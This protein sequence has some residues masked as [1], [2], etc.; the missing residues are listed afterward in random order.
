MRIV[1]DPGTPAR[2]AARRLVAFLASPRAARLVGQP[3]FWLV[4]RR[5]TIGEIDLARVRRVLVI[6]LDEI[7]DVAMTAPFLRE[8]RRN[9]AGAWISL[10]VKPGVFNLV[11]RC[12][13][14][15]EVLTFDWNTPPRLGR[16]RRHGRALRLAWRHLWARRF[17]LAVVPRWDVDHYHA[18]FVAYFSGA[19]WR[20]AYSEQVAALKR[21][22]N[23]G[24]DA[25]FTHVL[26]DD[27]PRHEVE[28]NLQVLRALGGTVADDRLELWVAPEDEAYADDVLRRNSVAPGEVLVGL[29]PAGGNSPFKQWPVDR[30]IA[31]AR[32]LLAASPVRL[33][34][35][36]GPGEEA[37]GEEMARTLGPSAINLVGRTTLRQ[38]AA[39]LHRCRLYVG[40][41]AGPMH[42]AAAVGTPVVA[43]FGSS[44][45]HRYS[46]WGEG[47]TVVWLG[48]PCSPCFQ[49]DHRDRCGTCLFDR[50][51]CLVDLP[52][53][54]VQQAVEAALEQPAR[55]AAGAIPRRHEALR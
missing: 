23:P 8:L 3:L 19:R 31:V 1:A 5:S 51:H 17:D 15:D 26:Q 32:R 28:R 7:G 13:Y 42:V 33:L 50:P 14:V 45:R 37:L 35:V 52:V 29:G 20:V 41:D 38:M 9:A 54:R 48:L 12:P 11:E 24:Y 4:G 22:L 2:A 18:A 49:P 36:G 21:R 30:F 53:D 25:L 6:R 16:L 27:T 55:P 46:P 44:C 39:F 40:N 10:V 43:V 34:V 47:H